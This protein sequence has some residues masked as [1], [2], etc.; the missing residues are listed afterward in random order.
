MGRYVTPLGVEIEM[1]DE[2]AAVIGYRPVAAAAE[3]KS[4]STP[5]G[6]AK[7]MKEDSE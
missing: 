6:K 1:G 2:A 4:K 3:P 7:T 5:K